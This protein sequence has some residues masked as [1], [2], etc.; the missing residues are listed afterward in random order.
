MGPA[1]PASGEFPAKMDIDYMRAYSNDPNVPAVKPQPGYKPSSTIPVP[2]VD[3][4]QH[5]AN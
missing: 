1:D 2:L 3:P 5:M 4:A